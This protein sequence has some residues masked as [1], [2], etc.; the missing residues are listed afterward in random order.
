MMRLLCLLGLILALALPPTRGAAQDYAQLFRSFEARLL[1]Q[2]D[3]RFLQT[4]L[5][6]EGHY[7]GLLDGDWGRISQRALQDYTL[8]TFG[9]PAEDWHMAFLAWSFFDR[10]QQDGWDM[11]YFAPMGM[12]VL[13]PDKTLIN[14]PPSNN[15]VNLRHARSSLS[16]SLGILT[17]RTAQS[18]HD[19]TLRQHLSRTEPY[20]VRK[21]NIAVTSVT[22]SDGSSLYTRSNF[23]NGAWSTI[24]LSADQGD[25]AVLMAVA[26]SISIGRAAP[27]ST[28]PNGRLEQAIMRTIALL[29][30]E[31][32][33]NT[34]APPAQD[35]ARPEGTRSGSGFIVSP[36]GHVLTNAHVVDGCQTITIDGT[37]A[38]LI[39]SS[40]DFDLALLQSTGLQGRTSAV[41]SASPAVLNSD[42]T[43]VGYPYAGLLG[44]LNVTRGAVSS[45]KGLGGDSTTMQITAP[46]QTG[47][48]GGPL[49]GAQGQV[50]GVVVSKLDVLKMVEVTGDIP[51]NVNFA[52]RGE[53][54][55]L[56]LAQNGVTPK[57]DLSNDPMSPEALAAAAQDFTAFIACD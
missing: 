11:R 51:Q 52:V 40:D 48:S 10:Y 53:I 50:V 35:T 49:L 55:K 6:F 42:V 26:A 38:K 28:T 3:K 44:G 1:T 8:Q 18:V 14:D 9:T 36:Q 20:R 21:R 32:F 22:E 31:D 43:A 15:F 29:E 4:A 17:E 13:L 33:D 54:A 30:N 47:N 45:L 46:V 23:I 41:F 25:H 39:E 57:L 5:A 2:Q 34:P 37:S 12:S 19:F 27:I 7:S 16:I 24:M 56:F